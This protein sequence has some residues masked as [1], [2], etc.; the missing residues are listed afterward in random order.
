MSRESTCCSITGTLCG[1]RL[2]RQAWSTSSEIVSKFPE[3]V[4]NDVGHD[5]RAGDRAATSAYPRNP[6]E[7]VLADDR[8]DLLGMHFLAADIDHALASADEEV[9]IAAQ[10]DHVAGIDETVRVS[11]GAAVAEIAQGDAVRADP[12]A[13]FYDTHF[14][15][16]AGPTDDCGGEA[17]LAVA[18]IEGDAGLG[19][20]EGVGHVR[21]R[22]CMRQIVQDRLVGRF[23]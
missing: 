4:N 16:R 10:L 15:R 1:G 14:D 7:R 3:R 22:P 6:H 13:T 8:L 5:D 12:Q 23:A 17:G 20:G 18:D 21:V 19:R 9:T 11:E 2:S